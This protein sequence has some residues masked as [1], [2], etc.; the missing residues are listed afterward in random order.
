MALRI[1]YIAAFGVLGVLSRYYLGAFVTRQLLPPFPYG[2]FLINFVGAFILG[3]IYVLG[4][5]R[6]AL[7]VDVRIGLMV[8]FLGGFTT[9]S[10]YCLEVLRLF[11]DG[12]RWYAVFYFTA[13]PI[14]GV[15]ACLAGIALGRGLK[16]LGL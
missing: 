15:A 6:A 7:S 11:E 13:S 9:F 8:G 3:L 12:E 5:E 4:V 14:V 10:S 16:G 1:G 2:T